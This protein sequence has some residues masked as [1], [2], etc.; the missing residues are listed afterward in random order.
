MTTDHAAVE[1]RWTKTEIMTQVCLGTAHECF[2][3]SEE[4]WFDITRMRKWARQHC[5]IVNVELVA[6]VHHIASTRVFEEERINTL[7][8][9]EWAND[10]VLFVVY[11]NGPN[12]VEHLMIDGH[13]RAMRAFR[14]G[15]ET[16]RAYMV[17][18]H[19]ITRPPKGF[20]HGPDWGDDLVDGKIVKRG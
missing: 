9:E 20:Q 11:E 6:F 3:H 14:E 19:A 18:E 15:A 16:V 17:P 4:G 5:A 12:G 10:P 1:K 7:T 8:M 13:H 2:E